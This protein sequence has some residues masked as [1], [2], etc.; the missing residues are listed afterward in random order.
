MVTAATYHLAEMAV[1][2]SWSSRF[3]SPSTRPHD[4][5]AKRRLYYRVGV[6]KYVLVDRGPQNEDPVRLIGY[7]TGAAWLASATP[8]AQ[9]RLDLGTSRHGAGIADDRPWLYERGH[10][11]TG[12]RSA[13]NGNRS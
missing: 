10:G 1:G 12:A 2:P 3:V 7:Q 6:Q 13:R 11:R 5:R 4:L 8:D 9:G